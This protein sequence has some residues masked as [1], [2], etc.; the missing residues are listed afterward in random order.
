[1]NRC[2]L[3]VVGV[4]VLVVCTCGTVMADVPDFVTYSGRLTD[5]TAWGKSEVMALTF[6][7]YDQ[8]EAGDPL[9]EQSFPA[10]AVE[11][12]HFS[13]ILGDG[14]NPADDSDLNVT[15]IFADHDQ[16]WVTVCVGEGCLVGDELMPRQAVGS[17]PCPS[18]KRV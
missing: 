3:I 9:W 6:R 7:I 16:T 13:V 17:V 15:D 4:A 10:V 11:D 18:G 5:G 1:M 12:G 8:A 2:G 14:K